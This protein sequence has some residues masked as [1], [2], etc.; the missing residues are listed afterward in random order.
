M[1]TEKLNNISVFR[2]PQPPHKLQWSFA[3]IIYFKRDRVRI[4]MPW[5]RMGRRTS[6]IDVCSRFEEVPHRLRRPPPT[7]NME[8]REPLLLGCLGQ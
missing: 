4:R 2:W 8:G 6:Y 5:T 3:T 7:R 1:P